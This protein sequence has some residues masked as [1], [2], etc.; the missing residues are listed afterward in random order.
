MKPSDQCL[1]WSAIAALSVLPL[2]ASSCNYAPSSP[3]SPG[4]IIVTETDNIWVTGS[5]IPIV[6]PKS[7]TAHTA[8]GIS[9]LTILS[10]EDM[11]RVA[12]ALM[13]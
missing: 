11:R 10:P 5:H 13:H 7:A 1:R 8:T 3:T 4:A 12:P 9:P 2:L 6:V